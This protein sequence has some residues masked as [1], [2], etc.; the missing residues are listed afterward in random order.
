VKD[1]IAK[2]KDAVRDLELEEVPVMLREALDA[3]E[4]PNMLLAG[5]CDGMAE[6]GKLFESGEYYLAD[7][8]LAGE[9]MKDGLEVLEPLLQSGEA[10]SKGTVVVCTVKGDVHD[11]GKN[12]VATMLKSSGFQVVDL[13]VDVEAEK[14]VDAVRSNGAGAVAL[15]VLL[16]SMVD[17]IGDVVRALDAAGLRDEVKIAIGG[18]CTTDELAE[19]MKVDALGRDAV[20][21]IR[22][23]ESFF[24]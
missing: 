12:L 21:A 22:I 2:V 6:V 23:F 13:G 8:V 17:S 10:Q 5:M 14:V 24:A 3:G 15:S 4:A 20:E 7:L 9:V 18:A 16:T 11:I 1:Y 19:R